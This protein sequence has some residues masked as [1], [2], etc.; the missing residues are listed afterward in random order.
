MPGRALEH[1]LSDTHAMTGSSILEK[2]LATVL[3]T[4]PPDTN[5]VSV[6][7]SP[8]RSVPGWDGK[9]NDFVGVLTTLG[10]V[11]SVPDVSV[12]QVAKLV[13]GLDVSEVISKLRA[14]QHDLANALAHEAPLGVGTFRWC[15][16]ATLPV[17]EVVVPQSEWVSP[18]DERVPNWLTAFNGDVLIA[19]DNDGR[20]GAGV[21]RKQHDQFGHE[22]SV[23]TEESLRGRGIARRLVQAATQRIISDG[24]LRHTFTTKPILRLQR[25]PTLRVFPMLVGDFSVF[26]KRRQNCR[27]RK[28]DA[29][30]GGY[31][32]S[33]GERAV[34]EGR[35]SGGACVQAGLSAAGYF[36]RR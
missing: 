9:I 25:L 30:T 22:I 10:G 14:H 19:W 29:Y 21:G 11:I 20:Y 17:D 12:E 26:G 2:H 35:N 15:G 7:S 8:N 27:T 13:D 34:R 23:G 24:P 6:V 4:W 36:A 3:G 1:R 33:R 32:S 18:H 31:A 5:R 28:Q 16:E